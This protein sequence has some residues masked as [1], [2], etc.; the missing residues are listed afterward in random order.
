MV[1]WKCIGVALKAGAQREMTPLVERI[2][3]KLREHGIDVVLEREAAA[4]SGGDGLSLEETAQRADLLIVLGGDGTVLA[5]ARAIGERNVAILGVNLGSLGFLT[6]V[7]PSDVDTALDGLLRGDYAVEE[8]ARLAVGPIPPADLPSGLVLNDVVISKGAGAARLIELEARVDGKS[9]GAY[10]ADGLVVSTPTGST[11]YNLSA[12]GPLV[13]PGVDAM[14]ITPICPHTLTQRPLV[15]SDRST[16]EVQLGS[17]ED[18]RLTLDGQVDCPL[19]E[20]DGIRVTRA[21]HPVR[22]VRPP[23]RDH[24]ETLR[25]KLGWGSQ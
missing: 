19:G 8:R 20:G 17:G 21:P 1:P 2:V 15:I 11:A 24:F 13:D 12:G 16:V 7:H 9:I 25:T 22:F 3:A 4:R 18:V 14:I 5:S 23:D 6:D 10:R